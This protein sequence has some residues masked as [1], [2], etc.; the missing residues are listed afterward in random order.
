MSR[1]P[2]QELDA[3]KA[4]ELHDVI[5]SIRARKGQA[6]GSALGVLKIAVL[7][8]TLDLSAQ[9]FAPASEHIVRKSPAASDGYCARRP[10]ATRSLRLT[11]PDEAGETPSDRC[12]NGVRS[13][14]SDVCLR[15]PGI[16]PGHRVG[17]ATGAA[18][19]AVPERPHR[20]A[21]KHVTPPF[22]TAP[23]KPPIPL[24]HGHHPPPY[25]MHKRAPACQSCN[26]PGASAVRR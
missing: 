13:L 14:R 6:Q 24:R 5:H 20:I 3:S 2:L 26:R 19:V 9:K 7:R 4:G 16:S 11:H 1:H 15:P 8:E 17:T 21:V 12:P 25:L 18:T 10:P 23:K 22:P